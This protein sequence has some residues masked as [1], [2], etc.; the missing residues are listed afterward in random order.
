MS[1]SFGQMLGL[2]SAFAGL[3]LGSNLLTSS[4][5]SSRAWKYAQRAMAL[6]YEYQKRG[7]LEGP[8]LS[9]KGV[10]DA[11]FNPLLALGSFGS[12]GSLGSVSSPNVPDMTADMPDLATSAMGAINGYKEGQLLDT[13]INSAKTQSDILNEQLEKL[14]ADNKTSPKNLLTNPKARQEFIEGLPKPIKNQVNS[15]LKVANAENK[16]AKVAE[17]INSAMPEH[18]NLSKRLMSNIYG[19][20]SAT[21]FGSMHNLYNI[22]KGTYR[23]IKKLHNKNS[24]KS[25]F[26]TSGNNK[27]KVEYLPELDALG[28]SNLI[29]R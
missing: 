3:G 17:V 27:Y 4:I 11:G 15:A 8:S 21:P 24:A 20:Y 29:R 14:R 18:P 9:R 1:L 10:T 23:Y 12:S 7:L 25:G 13:N 22:S 6:Q 16:V 2:G 19:A 5:S 26:V 28:D